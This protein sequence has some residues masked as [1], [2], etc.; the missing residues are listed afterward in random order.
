MLV[1]IGS[2]AVMNRSESLQWHSLLLARKGASLPK[3]HIVMGL[4]RNELMERLAVLLKEL[5]R[6]TA[7]Y[8]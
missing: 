2:T 7:T 8:P 3:A 4:A 5:D 1:L 6:P